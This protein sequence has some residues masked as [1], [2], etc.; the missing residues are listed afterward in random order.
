MMT[1]GGA[2]AAAVVVVMAVTVKG[3]IAMARRKWSMLLRKRGRNL[4]WRSRER[5]QRRGPLRRRRLWGK[6][7]GLVLFPRQVLPGWR[8]EERRGRREDG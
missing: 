7:Q 3:E 6:G 1:R 2:A 4:C 5:A 8:G